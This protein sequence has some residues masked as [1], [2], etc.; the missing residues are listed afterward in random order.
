MTADRTCDLAPFTSPVVAQI[1]T[2]DQAASAVEILVQSLENF[3]AR[4][5]LA[6]CEDLTQIV[7][8]CCGGEQEFSFL[9]LTDTP[10][11]YAGS[12]GYAVA[13]NAG[14]SGLEFIPFPD[15]PDVNVEIMKWVNNTTAFVTTNSVQTIGYGGQTG[16]GGTISYPAL[17]TTDNSTMHYRLQMATANATNQ[18]AHAGSLSL[19]LLVAIGTTGRFAGFR[20][21]A[22]VGAGSAITNQRAFWGLRG[23]TGNPT[24]VNPSSL[25][26]IIGIGYDSGDGQLQ[27]MHN[28]NAGT[29][30][31]VPLGVN[32]PNPAAGELFY[33][34]LSCAPGA[35]TVDYFVHRLNTGDET[36]GTINSD[37]PATT[38][39]LTTNFWV[40]TGANAGVAQL[41]F[42]QAY[43][44]YF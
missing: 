30:T 19:S 42:C 4:F 8:E 33:F 22:L 38:Q 35:S 13:V 20:L 40:G 28:D 14:A 24:S 44:S 15:T 11:T 9:D 31:K 1:A 39:F 25:V 36:S 32:F 16:V 6:V 18:I 29:A 27:L 37:L 43:L 3:L 5:K 21:T 26:N 17:A 12:A 10:D 41:W 34:E 2:L 7:E 23:A